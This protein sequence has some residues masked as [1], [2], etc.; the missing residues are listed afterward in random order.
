MDQGETVITNQRNGSLPLAIYP[1]R[2]KRFQ[3]RQEMV[4]W[5]NNKIH[6]L[7]GRKDT[8]GRITGALQFQY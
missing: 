3:S 6:H 1:K 5:R 7:H 8:K 4:V 2:K